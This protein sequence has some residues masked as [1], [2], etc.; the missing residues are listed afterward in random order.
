MIKVIGIDPAPGKASHVV[1]DGL[2]REPM[3]A[4]QLASYLDQLRGQHERVLVCWDAPLSGPADPDT[5]EVTG[6]DHTQRPIE[7]FFSRQAGYKAPTGISVLPY[8][9]CPHW[10]IS[11]RLLGLPRTGPWMTSWD[12]LPFYL[13][14][15]DRMPARDGH[16]IAEVH[17]AV[18]LWLWGIDSDKPPSDWRYK[19]DAT[20]RA[21]MWKMLERRLIA[22]GLLNAGHVFEPSDDDDLDA[23]VAWALGTFWAEG[24]NSVGLLGN[25]STGSF[26]VPMNQDA[27]L[28]EHFAVFVS[29]LPDAPQYQRQSSN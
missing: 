9:G 21:Q 7:K 28:R 11:Q 23:F 29:G 22:D 2:P 12:D 17:P 8:G 3:P 13:V 5:L 20:V 24:H 27:D 10:T 15:E 14:E 4:K 25:R 1:E 6:S 16:Y 18:A 19:K 26:L